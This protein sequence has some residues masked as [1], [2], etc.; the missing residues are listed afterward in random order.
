MLAADATLERV[1]DPLREERAVREPGERVVECLVGELILERPS[2]GDVASGDDD[3]ADVRDGLEQVVEDAF[4]LDDGAVLPAV[5]SRSRGIGVAGIAQTSAKKPARRSAS[6]R[7]RS[8]G[9]LRP[10]ELVLPVAE[11]APRRTG[12]W[13]RIVEI[14]RQ[15]ER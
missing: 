13:Y 2:L 15:E 1:R 3:A 10:D 12:V 9:Q 14:R 7:S 6:S 11:D 5:A 8:S 4:E